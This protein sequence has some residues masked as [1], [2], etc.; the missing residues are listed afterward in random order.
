MVDD[1]TVMLRT[2]D[3][4]RFCGANDRDFEIFRAAAQGTAIDVREFTDGMP[5][6]CLQGPKSREILQ[7]VANRDISG[8][9]FPYY[10]FREDVSI[11]GIPVFMTR[12]GYTAELGYELWVDRERALE[13]WD[14]LIEAGRHQAA[15]RNAPSVMSVRGRRRPRS[16]RDRAMRS[17]ASRALRSL[18]AASTSS[19]RHR[20]SSSGDQA[21]PRQPGGKNT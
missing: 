18:Y 21:G 14:V 3:H 17:R 2:P 9:V 13:L 12:L 15:P 7:T 20:T 10:S 19:A 1:C 8:A 6:L 11:A 16:G 5:H 4:V